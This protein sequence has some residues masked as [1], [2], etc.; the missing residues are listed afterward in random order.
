MFNISKQVTLR[1]TQHL[2]FLSSHKQALINATPSAYVDQHTAL[3]NNN[4]L[5]PDPTYQV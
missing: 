3:K 5:T 1:L 4:W 2:A